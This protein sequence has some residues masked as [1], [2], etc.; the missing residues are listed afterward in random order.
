MQYDHAASH[1]DYTIKLR[2]AQYVRMSTDYQIYST[3]NQ[4]DAIA[5]YAAER[6]ITIVRSY[7]DEGRSGLR[8]DDRHALKQLISDVLLG[9]A[10]FGLIL[11]YDVSR[12]GRFQDTD[13][14][15]H[16]EFICKEAGV[17]IEYCAEGFQNDGSLMSSVIKNLKR[18]MA[19]EYS[20]ELSTKVFAAQCRLVKMGFW[21]GGAPG[22]GLRRQ[23]IDENGNPK[24][25]LA[26]GQRK[27]L[28]TDRVILLPGPPNELELVRDVFSQFA[29][30]QKPESRIA[31]DL[32]RKGLLTITDVHGQVGRSAVF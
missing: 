19:G 30:E 16:Y 29:I 8:L 3:Q 27:H 23:L 4:A 24:G 26:R 13:E 25:L 10:D 14:S 22:F 20:R 18:A 11:V 15:A 21:Q 12:W 2:A 31:R 32:N 7:S 1:D 9:R 17:R 28:Q 5:R 6:N